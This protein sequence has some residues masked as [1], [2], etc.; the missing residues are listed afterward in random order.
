MSGV[1]APRI[2]RWDGQSW[3]PLGS[4]MNAD[5]RSII[6]RV[7]NGQ[8]VIYVAG[9]FTSAGGVPARRV[10]RWNGQ[11][12]SAL[13]TGL[14]GGV[15]SLAFVDHGAGPILYACG[16]FTHT[17]GI[18]GQL[19]NRVARW[20]GEIWSPLGQGITDSN[21][22]ATSLAVFDDGNG[23]ALYM[24]GFFSEVDGKP[25]QGLAKWDGSQWSQVGPSGSPVP[26]PVNVQT[27]NTPT[28]PA[29][30]VLG[31]GVVVRWNGVTWTRYEPTLPSARVTEFYD[32]GD[33]PQLHVGG[34]E[35][36]FHTKI[37]RF[38][39]AGNS[40]GAA[41]GDFDGDGVVTQADLGI[42]LANYTCTGAP[43]DCP[44]DTDNDGD[45]DQSDLGTLLAN[46][47]KECG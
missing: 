39:A 38:T 41:C 16:F 23:P 8:T 10:A 15:E 19:V 40:G 21:G 45:V 47:G 20:D 14:S 11:S 33:G 28:G 2:A 44:G 6:S 43:G 30:F 31:G 22:Y 4:G 5:V 9:T 18:G 29:L 7:E 42:L 12:W 27:H 46:F 26:W 1:A 34:G 13:G 17:G 3:H 37:A 25:I 35:A 24:G 36:A 32:S